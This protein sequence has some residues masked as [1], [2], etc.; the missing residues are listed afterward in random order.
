ME[1]KYCGLKRTGLRAQVNNILGKMLSKTSLKRKICKNYK[2][3]CDVVESMDIDR[4]SLESRKDD[5]RYEGILSF[6]F[7]LRLKRYIGGACDRLHWINRYEDYMEEVVDFRTKNGADYEKELAIVHRHGG[8]IVR[9]NSVWVR[10]LTRECIESNPGPS[11]TN[12]QYRKYLMSVYFKDFKKKYEQPAHITESFLICFYQFVRARN[13]IDISVAILNYLK[14]VNKGSLLTSDVAIGLISKV[15]GILSTFL[16]SEEEGNFIQTL[17]KMVDEYDVV[18][19]STMYKKVYKFFMYLLS[20]SIFEKL[21]LKVCDNVYTKLERE[22]IRKKFYLG[23]DFLHCVI[24]TILFIY[25]RGVQC[26]KLGRLDPLYHDELMYSNWSLKVIE[27]KNKAQ[28]LSNPEPHNF[29]LYDYLADLKH[30]LEEGRVM[31]RACPG[32]DKMAKS[33]IQKLVGELEILNSNAISRREAQRSREAPFALLLYGGSSIAKSTLCQLLFSYFGQLHDLPVDDEYLY[34]RNPADEYWVNFN[35]TQWCV[36]M[37]DI[38]YLHPN[39]STNVDKTLNEIIQV[40]NSTSFVPTQAA[41]EDKGKTPMRAKL[42]LATTNT[43]DIQANSYF[44]CPLAVQRRLPFV[45]QIR[46]KD[47]YTIHECMLDG[48]K[49]PPITS[50]SYPDYWCFQVFRVVPHELNKP[51]ERQFAQHRLE[52][53]FDNINDLLRWVGSASTHFLNLQKKESECKNLMKEV[54]VCKRCFMP[55]KV[56]ECSLN[57]QSDELDVVSHAEVL[58]NGQRDESVPS[59]TDRIYMLSI[60]FLFSVPFVYDLIC[61]FAAQFVASKIFHNRPHVLEYFGYML[62]MRFRLTLGGLNQRSIKLYLAMFTSVSASYMI[63]NYLFKKKDEGFASQG[64]VGAK[65][66]PDEKEIPNVW[67]KDDYQVTDLD[68]SRVTMSMKGLG[69]DKIKSMLLENCVTIISSSDDHTHTWTTRA[70]CIGGQYYIMNNHSLPDYTNHRIEVICSPVDE[71]VREKYN[72]KVS[73]NM[74]SR[75]ADEDLCLLWLP[76]VRPRRSYMKLLANDSLK[77]VHQGFLLDRDRSG[78]CRENRVVKIESGEQFV[79]DL[80]TTLPVWRMIPQRPTEKG[81]CGSLCVSIGHSGPIILGIHVAMATPQNIISTRVSL[82]SFLK[83]RRKFDVPMV[84]SNKVNFSSDTSPQKLVELNRKSEVRFIPDGN[85]IVYGSFEN[86]G[87]RP[88][89][90]VTPSPLSYVLTDYGYKIQ[91]GKPAMKGWEPWYNNLLPSLEP[92][93][94]LDV[95]LLME[96]AESLADDIVA[97]LSPQDTLKLIEYDDF[98][99]TNGAAGVRFVD[100]MNRNTSAGFP[101]NKSKRHFI[102]PIHPQ[103]GLQDPVEFNDEIKKRIEEC[104]ECYDNLTMYHPIYMASLKDEPRSFKKIQEKNTRVFTGGPVEHVFVTRKE[105]LSYTKIMQENK[106]VSECAAGTIAQSIEWDNIYRYLTHFGED[107]IFDGDYSK[108]DKSMESVAILAVFRTITRVLQHCGASEDHIQRCWCIGYDL[109]FAMINYNGTLLQMGKGHVSGEALTVLVNSH[110][111]SLYV[112]YAYMLSHPQRT[113]TDFK[114]NITLM[115]YGDDFV[116]GVN[117]KCDFF[118]FRILQSRMKE[119]GL[120]VTPADKEADSYDLMNIKEINFLKRSFRFEPQTGTFMCP[121]DEE[122]IKKSLMVN[123]KSKTIPE[124]MQSAECIASA[125]REYFWHGKQKFENQRE[126]LKHIVS[127]CPEVEMYVT[128]STFPTWDQLMESYKEA[129]KYVE[130]LDVEAHLQIYA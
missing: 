65:P 5:K 114:K 39:K 105:L 89:S 35:T 38:A 124:E 107:R 26:V 104:E 10:E 96:C 85:A 64:N 13:R 42:V 73:A 61:A 81:D 52:H 111:N 72:I 47:E 28:H 121:L 36:L 31:Y 110:C 50:E 4:V 43:K 14:H 56:C 87:N 23:P 58:R 53:E 86:H 62:G 21:G 130:R 116:G 115:T 44:S 7:D 103:H 45:I 30:C 128:D 75:N 40:V 76:Q 9:T 2:I 32:K 80:N 100:K 34:T 46:P 66:E 70:F 6:E 41:L 68:I 126:F 67:Y 15:D 20:F 119:M 51:E 63:Y 90:H 19:S 55:S 27:L 109:A 106:F 48:S 77:G 117:P 17:R 129:S 69:E 22:A 82:Q 83:L 94:H 3:A 12:V 49:V 88:K 79:K 25:T 123:V 78:R 127:L 24:D 74:I 112:R 118:N 57:I 8:R 113:C 1:V 92:N 60:W 54:T 33:Y 84:Q 59:F 29:T 95:G 91:H 18:K 108:F 101:F 98:T 102:N 11:F 122:S 120:K 97:G 99:V 125:I 37:D 93:S 16:Q 71:G